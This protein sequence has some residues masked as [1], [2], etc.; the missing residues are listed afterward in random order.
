MSVSGGASPEENPIEK[1]EKAEDEAR[2]GLGWLESEGDGEM[3]LHEDCGAV[4][5][6]IVIRVSMECA[7]RCKSLWHGSGVDAKNV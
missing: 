7:G 5:I 6:Y 1:A 3:E 2:S 4:G